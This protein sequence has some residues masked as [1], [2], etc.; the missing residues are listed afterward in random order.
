MALLANREFKFSKN[1]ENLLKSE[2]MRKA[3]VWISGKFRRIRIE[4]GLN[5]ASLK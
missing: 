5:D 1:N 3:K 4:Q 2:D